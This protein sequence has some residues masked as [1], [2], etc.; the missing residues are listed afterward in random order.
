M[1]KLGY[2]LCAFFAVTLGGCNHNQKDWVEPKMTILNSRVQ[3]LFEKTKA[4]CFGRFLIDVPASAS[5]FW[6]TSIVPLSVSVYPNG[7]AEVNEMAE[8]FVL[9]LKSEKAIYLNHIPLLVGAEDVA[10]P[11][12]K[13]ITGY[14]S[15]EAMHEF[16]INGYFRLGNAGVV[17]NARPLEE[18]RDEARSLIKSIAQRLQHRAE[19]EIPVETGNC[20]EFAFLRDVP[21]PRPDD[22][23]EHIRIG[24]RLAEFPDA[25][26][27][28]YVAPSNPH[29][30]ENDS[31]EK[32][33]KRTFADMTSPEE[34]KVLENTKIFRQSPR[35]IHDWKTGFEVLMR[36][37]DEEGSLA[38]HDFRM[39]FVGVPHDPYKPYADIQFQTGVSD[40]AAGATK[41]TLT[42]DEALAI[43][44]KI[45]STI[46]VRPTRPAGGK[47]AAI[48]PAARLPLG[49]L[50]ATGRTC[51]QSGMWEPNE[52]AGMEG[53]RRRHI[54][55]GERMP[56][57][58]VQTEP[59]VWQKLKGERP[60]YQTGAI[61]KLVAYD[62]D[63]SITP[64]ATVSMS[65]TAP[66]DAAGVAAKENE[67]RAEGSGATAQSPSKKES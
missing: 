44:D 9:E 36:S 40:N 55:A 12:G 52:P 32:Q 60:A 16:R 67:N 25:H 54:K 30:P 33:F 28:I 65:A 14:E 49:E 41:A 42:D 56:H 27:S 61:W 17:I 6:G 59:S 47:S 5:I 53:E 13:L 8:K 39:K 1:I 62:I 24:V 51:P 21:N 29:D 31:L 46:R 50:A 26:I 19:N 58:T 23:L 20:I 64:D 48:S 37:P 35:Q 7:V 15:F 2:F 63:A 3:P 66:R 43:W 4:V 45:T 18:D 22:L 10:Q 57:I 34:K 11:E 38:H